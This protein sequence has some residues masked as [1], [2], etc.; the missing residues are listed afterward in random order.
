M[1][2]T[3]SKDE[4]TYF[5]D[6]ESG[7]ETARLVELAH[8]LTNQLG[9]LFPEKFTFSDVNH[10]LEIACGPGSWAL[11]VAYAYPEISVVGVDVNDTM[12]RYATAQAITQGLQNV[13]FEM[14]NVLKP[15][16]FPDGSF[17]LVHARL[18]QGFMPNAAWPVFLQEC[19][20]VIRPG[21]SIILVECETPITNSAIIEQMCALA[22]RAVQLAGLIFSPDGR[23]TG[24]TPMLCRF[25]RDA[26]YQD[27]QH[28]AHAID[29]SVG[30]Q[31]H[32]S[33][34][35]NLLVLAEL[36]KPFLVKAG[37][38]AREEL[39]SLIDK[40]AMEEYTSDLCGIWYY[41]S[42]WGR[43]PENVEETPKEED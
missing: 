7:A 36:L 4:S 38:I 30:A 35:Q 37:V 18:L 3:P 1:S 26:G 12:I 13:S 33:T 39:D 14:M 25:L 21:G 41:L 24:I 17:D 29:F 8:L 2:T 32:A 19:R 6:I 11:D 10:I 20:R 42:V 22:N 31:A 28:M 27:V 34:L 15:L 43:K 16:E 5:I 9:G 40:I 23:H